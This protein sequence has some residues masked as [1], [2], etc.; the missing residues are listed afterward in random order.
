MNFITEN[1]LGIKQEICLVPIR[2]LDT[3]TMTSRRYITVTITFTDGKYE[4][5]LTFLIIPAMS[6]LIPSQHIDSSTFNIPKNIKLADPRFHLP[7][8]ID[9]LL[10][11]GTKL[12]LMCVGQINL[13]QPGDSELRL[14]K[15][16]FGSVIGG[17]PTSQTA[18]NIFHASTTA[19]QADLTRFWKIDEGPPIQH[20]SEADRRCEEHFRAHVRRT[21]EG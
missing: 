18:T 15:T 21:S 11:S 20:I 1:S 3:L 17:S 7:A 2:V 5:P 12:A 6:I 14:Q 13:T 8:P 19:P 16:L 4:R 9:A 10:S